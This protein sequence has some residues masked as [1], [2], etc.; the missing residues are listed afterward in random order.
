MLNVAAHPFSRMRCLI[1]SVSNFGLFFTS[2]DFEQDKR[3]EEETLPLT[4]LHPP[5][6]SY[7]KLLHNWIDPTEVP[8]SDRG[9]RI[10]VYKDKKQNRLFIKLAERLTGVQ[11][12]V[13]TYMKRPPYI[14]E[15]SFI[16]LAGSE[17]P[18]ECSSFPHAL[19]FHSDIGTFSISFRSMDTLAIGLPN[20]VSSGIRMR[21]E[22]NSIVKEERS[23]IIHALRNLH[24]RCHGVVIRHEI[25]PRKDGI[26][27]DIILD[28]GVEST[29]DLTPEW[30]G[31][32]LPP[33][34]PA[35]ISIQNAESRWHGWFSKA[36]PFSGEH[37]ANYYYAW[38]VMA[39]NL[40][41]PLGYLRYEAMMPSKDFYVGVWNWD[42]CLHAVALRHMDINLARNQLRAVLDWQCSDGMLP[43]A[44]YDE[45]I[46]DF[47]D[48]PIPGRVT[49]PPLIAWSAMKLHQSHPDLNF[50]EEI[51]SPLIRWNAWWF[52][53][54]DDDQDGIVQYSHPYSSGLDDSPLW[55]D[56]MPVE[57][58]DLNTYLFI[59]MVALGK[60][61][62]EL[63][64]EDEAQIW[65]QRSSSL[66]EKMIDHFYDPDSG[67]FW[68]MHNHQPIPEVTP[69][70]LYPLWTG[71]LSAEIK[72][73]LVAHLVNP[74]KFWA[75]YP[76]TTVARNSTHYSPE[77]MWRGP[78]W[79]NINYFF[80]EALAR[81]G[82]PELARELRVRTIEMIAKNKGI[83]EFYNPETG[84]PAKRAVP[85]FAWTA[86]VFIDLLLQD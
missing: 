49:K 68:A 40:V 9:S 51:Y 1:L 62:E 76:L 67:I 71:Q 11:P 25:I 6:S 35:S 48:H 12:G 64:L 83:H 73:K 36:P 39:N 85:M 53:E 33:S 77:T 16:N 41:S 60:M 59:Q 34:L 72:E 70:N 22:G 57:S 56:G 29:I 2:L 84:Q 45:N 4:Q 10:L 81:S 32:S 3:I 55:D 86:A 23:G 31:F 52:S 74:E 46:V 58:P 21:L 26:Q 5:H 43:D 78:V 8:F 15:L 42:A 47:I 28:A 75:T 80:V 54:N 13:E 24:Y 20:G 27:V 79:P 18:F 61:A 37:E 14:P 19:F 50:L 30:P 63:G 82:Y 69:F 38:W 17:I 7:L 66:L 44:I 65:R